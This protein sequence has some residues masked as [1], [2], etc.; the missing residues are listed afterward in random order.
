MKRKFIVLLAIFF[1]LAISG[2]ILIQVS[3]IKNAIAIT[4]QQF[5]YMAN[6]ALESVVLDLEEKEL[7]ENIVEEIKPASAD[8]VTVIVPA[9]SPFARKLQG[10][11]PG[12]TLVE[13]N[14]T[15]TSDGTVA[16]TS[17]GHKIFIAAENVSP[18]SSGEINEPSPQVIHSEIGGRVS[19]KIIFLENVMEKVLR[20]TP[21]IRDRIN[22]E[23]IQKRIRAALNNVEIYL[24]FEFS[25]RS[26]RLG[27][28]WKTP[29]F[30]DKP[31]TNKFIIQLFPNDPIPSQNQIVLYCLQEKQYKF[32]KIG[33]LGVFSI[34]FTLLLTLLST[35]TF[36]VIF[37]QKKI[38]E[39][40]NDFINNM[41]HELKTP[42]STISLASQMLADK[43]ITEREKNSEALAKIISD[44]SMRLKYQVEKVLQMAIFEK[45]KMKLNMV[46]LDLHSL[47]N[48]TINNFNLQIRNSQGVIKKDFRAEKTEVLA[49]E[50]HIN[51]AISNLIDNAIKY[52]KDNPE[53]IISTINNADRI[54]ITVADNG[55]G[56]SKEDINRIFEKFYRVPAG[57]VHNVKGF[58]LGLSYV[59]KI[60]AEHNGEIKVESNLNKGTRFTVILPLNRLK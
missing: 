52:S 47:L 6:K 8:S 30:T 18:Y 1:F 16:I 20:N 28:I 33:N 60:I 37:R 24:D 54:E 14:N 57:N 58:G 23:D 51:N 22:P 56:I 3:W 19:N 34:L 44:E 48:K 49:D 40:R 45:V 38:S 53:I 12:S 32:E 29:G 2:L 39:I 50:V 9:N 13:Q 26:G 43:S 36:I 42:I 27:T 55:I 21:D 59:Q 4:D 41:T 35:G 31:G 7:I 46:N 5:R 15:G 11:R 25:I 17:S 10:Y